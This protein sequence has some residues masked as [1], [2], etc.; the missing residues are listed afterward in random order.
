MN[1]TLTRKLD[2]WH[3]KLTVDGITTQHVFNV[4]GGGSALVAALLERKSK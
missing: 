3:V 2:G 1:A 4:I